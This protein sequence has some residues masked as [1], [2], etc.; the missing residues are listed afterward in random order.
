MKTESTNTMPEGKFSVIVVGAGPVGLTAAHALSKAGIDFTVLEKRE[1]ILENIGATIILFPHGIRPLAQLGLEEKLRTHGSDF[2]TAGYQTHA[3]GG[4]VYNWSKMGQI[5]KENHGTYGLVSARADVVKTLYTS[6]SPAEQSRILPGKRV[7]SITDNADSEDP[8]RR[9]TVTCAD[10]TTY[11]ST[12]IIGADGI[13]SQARE[14]MHSIGSSDQSPGPRPFEA[15]YRA[16]W[17][18]FPRPDSVPATAGFESHGQDFSAQCLNAKD[19]SF[20]IVYQ[21]LP[22]HLHPPVKGYVGYTEQDIEA[23]AKEC[24]DAPVGESGLKLRDVWDKKLGPAG[25]ANLEEGVLKRWSCGGGK[26]VLIGDSAHKITPNQGFGLN[27]GIN[28]VVAVTNELGRV[29]KQHTTGVPS[30]EELQEA[31]NRYQEAREP[32]A[33]KDCQ[34]SNFSIQLGTWKNKL[35][36]RVVSTMLTMPLVEPWLI[37]KL[38]T[39]LFS[40]SSLVFDHIEMEGEPFEGK[41]PFKVAIPKRKKEVVDSA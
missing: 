25:M 33:V 26:I 14:A 27:D 28:D 13:Y 35:L 3:S 24:G 18:S 22:A 8:S 38:Y 6:L 23:V 5:F 11:S 9:V 2:I 17:F 36:W 31:F 40:Q 34:T 1:T 29:L 39:P 15:N 10:G 21:K 37:N 30:R 4:K 12:I 19:V 7:T 32:W 41:V 20:F 16:M